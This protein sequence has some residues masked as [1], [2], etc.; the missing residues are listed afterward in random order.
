MCGSVWSQLPLA[1]G[2]RGGEQAGDRGIQDYLGLYEN[3][4]EQPRQIKK[5]HYFISRFGFVELMTLRCVN[6]YIPMQFE[7]DNL[8]KQWTTLQ[9]D[10]IQF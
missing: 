6:L 2:D 5:S 7:V 1:R 3:P 4:Q 8:I 9:I 10:L